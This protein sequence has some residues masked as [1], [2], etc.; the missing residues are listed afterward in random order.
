MANLFQVFFT[1]ITKI[2]H[3]RMLPTF[4]SIKPTLVICLLFTGRPT[5]T[6]MNF[7][8]VDDA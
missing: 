3:H 8:A 6:M 7:V 1:G 4:D 2:D 5:T